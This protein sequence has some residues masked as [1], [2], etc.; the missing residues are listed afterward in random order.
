MDISLIFSDQ[1]NLLPHGPLLAV[2]RQPEMV[3]RQRCFS[4]G[5]RDS[6]FRQ[7]RN[8]FAGLIVV[9]N[10]SVVH[11]RNLYSVAFERVSS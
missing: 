6:E 7:P 1:P 8:F 10:D 4:D 11:S 2:V 9:K 3:F 5:A